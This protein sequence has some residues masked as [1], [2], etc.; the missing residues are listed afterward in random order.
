MLPARFIRTASIECII[1]NTQIVWDNTSF[2]KWTFIYD[3]L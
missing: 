1:I 2:T 3:F